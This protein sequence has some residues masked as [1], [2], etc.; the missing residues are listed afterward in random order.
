MGL[1]G[2]TGII[3]GIRLLELLRDVDEVETHLVMSSAA[4][5]TL[6]LETD[7]TPAQLNALAD[8]VHR[9]SDIAAPIASGSYPALGMVIIPCSVKTLSGVATSYGDNLLIRAA[10]VTLKERRRLVLVLRETPF[11]LG[12]IRLM[13]QVAEMGGVIMPPVPAFYH[14]PQTLDD[15]INHTVYRVLDLF[16]IA[17]AADLFARWGE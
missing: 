8:H 12:H 13:A 15:L 3:Y 11:H 6:A 14:R 16:G 9:F 2:A 7:Y 17:L 1:S 5:R 4:R 10:D